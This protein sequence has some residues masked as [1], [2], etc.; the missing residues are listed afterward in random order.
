MALYRAQQG[1]K[2]S[3]SSKGINM[4][5]GFIIAA[6]LGVGGGFAWYYVDLYI[7]RKKLDYTPTNDYENHF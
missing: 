6:V 7:E 4:I 1:S 2:K 5:I 3:S